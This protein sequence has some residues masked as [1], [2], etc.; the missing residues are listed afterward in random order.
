MSCSGPFGMFSPNG[1]R[2]GTSF[3]DCAVVLLLALRALVSGRDGMS[4]D[5]GCGRELAE[6]LRVGDVGL[7]DH[8]CGGHAG[9]QCHAP[10]ARYLTHN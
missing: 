3:F 6:E 4:C 5:G 2:I 10:Y 1:C 8:E 9:E 7:A